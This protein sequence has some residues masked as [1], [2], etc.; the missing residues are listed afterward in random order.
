MEQPAAMLQGQTGAW[1]LLQIKPSVTLSVLGNSFTAI[2]DGHDPKKGSYLFSC[3]ICCLKAEL[4]FAIKLFEI[5]VHPSRSAWTLLM[6]VSWESILPQEPRSCKG[7]IP[8]TAPGIPASRA[9]GRMSLHVGLPGCCS[10]PRCFRWISLKDAKL[11]RLI[12]L[13]M[14]T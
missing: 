9:G 13:R 4:M 8:T 5:G 12:S 1:R 11:T 2:R 6:D 3:F 14:L 10:I 7:K